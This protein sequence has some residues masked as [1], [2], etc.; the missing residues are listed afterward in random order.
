MMPAKSGITVYGWK[1]A[2]AIP[3]LLKASKCKLIW[4]VLPINE[5]DWMSYLLVV[6]PLISTEDFSLEVYKLVLHMEE[7]E[8]TVKFSTLISTEL[9]T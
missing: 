7:T 3:G 9:S 2:P 4:T 6:Q 1:T 5:F 8:C